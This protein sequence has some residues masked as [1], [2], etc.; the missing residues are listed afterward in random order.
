MVIISNNMNQFVKIGDTYK[1]TDSINKHII[2]ICT[3]NK[4]K[5]RMLIRT[6][7]QG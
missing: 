6:D 5:T 4:E 3:L 2:L 7:F 1:Y